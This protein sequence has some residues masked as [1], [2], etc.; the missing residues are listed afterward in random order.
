[1]SSKCAEMAHSTSKAE[2]S[3]LTATEENLPTKIPPAFINRGLFIIR[4]LFPVKKLLQY[5]FDFP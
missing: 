5:L 4:Q 1:P 3:T 2:E